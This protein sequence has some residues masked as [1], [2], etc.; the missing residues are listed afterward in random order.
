MKFNYVGD[1]GLMVSELCFGTMTFG[2]DSAG[3]WSKIA[4]VDQK[5]V[6]EMLKA[7]FDAGIN[8]IDTANVY[9]F[10]QSEQLLGQGLK[11]LGTKR[12]DVVIATKVLGPMS[13]KPNDVG[14]SRYHIFNS[15]DASLKRLQL[16]HI[17]IL[18]VHGVDPRVS[19]EEILKTLNDIVATGKVRYIAICNWP[20]WMVAKAQAIAKYNGWQKFIGL[21]YYYSA[22]TRDIET[23]LVPMAADHNLAIFP[24]SPLAGGFLTGK[25]AR[26]G[27][28]EKGSRRADFDFPPINKDKAFNLVDVMQEIAIA[29]NVTVAEIALAWVR[30]QKGVTSTIIG[31]KT[32]K[33]LHSNIKS[34]EINLSK[35]DLD[36]IDAVSAKPDLYPGWM[37][38]RQSEYRK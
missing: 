33:Q 8:F 28:S 11:D 9:S 4:A 23:E 32:I 21:Q 37:V 5:E 24:W 25:Y 35:N 16:D 14:L 17:D 15:V 6:N 31:A 10:G 7:V 36:K 34:T 22:V 13:Q 19:V 12:D 29:H 2:G 30:H 1:T 3:M 26:E 18:Y 27:S 20:A 38:E